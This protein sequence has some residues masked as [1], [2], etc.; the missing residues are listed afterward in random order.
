MT[1]TGLD[2][3]TLTRRLLKTSAPS[4]SPSG[5][6]VAG[7]ATPDWGQNHGIKE[8]SAGSSAH[9]SALPTGEQMI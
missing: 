9:H 4:G 6:I 1:P 5:E 7:T 2:E 3:W 8:Y